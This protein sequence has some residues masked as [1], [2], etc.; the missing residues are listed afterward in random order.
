PLKSK[1]DVFGSDFFTIFPEHN[2]LYNDD[3]GTL[4]SLEEFF[5]T[6]VQEVLLRE[7]ST[8]GVKCAMR[9][10]R[11]FHFRVQIYP[12][13]DSTTRMPFFPDTGKPRTARRGR[14]NPHGSASVVTPLTKHL[15]SQTTKRQAT[16][17]LPSSTPTCKITEA[18]VESSK[19]DSENDFTVAVSAKACHLKAEEKQSRTSVCQKPSPAAVTRKFAEKITGGLH[20]DS[21][22][23]A[24][25]KQRTEDAGRSSRSLPSSTR[26]ANVSQDATQPK[27]AGS[28]SASLQSPSSESEFSVGALIDSLSMDNDNVVSQTPRLSD[29]LQK[30]CCY[31]SGTKKTRTSEIGTMTDVFFGEAS[32]SQAS[33]TTAVR[34]IALLNGRAEGDA[35]MTFFDLF[36]VNSLNNDLE[37]MRSGGRALSSF[38]RVTIEFLDSDPEAAD[39]FE[40]ALGSLP[41]LRARTA[42]VESARLAVAENNCVEIGRGIVLFVSFL[43][44][45]TKDD[46]LRTA[47]SV[48]NVKLC[49]S[50]EGAL[51]SV[52]ELPG[53]VLVVPQAC[54][55]GKRKG[56]RVQY[57]GL[58][59]KDTGQEFYRIFVEQCQILMSERQWCGGKRIT[60]ARSGT[61]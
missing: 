11:H 42:T 58:V 32:A 9:A 40:P 5:L 37:C 36:R 50:G 34:L 3:A 29:S 31:C 22:T 18:N 55:A 4:E 61:Y 23:R 45:A 19:N 51:V 39:P 35:H 53:D 28:S 6:S 17:S 16:K 30:S 38:A 14:E 59:S 41:L 49:D 47:K 13:L 52:L 43:E 44:N 48:L 7:D 21:S 12:G 1:D 33:Q 2:P 25:G 54:L 56:K 10:H 46:V 57:H 27:E 20:K 60:T 15:P 26:L 8:G 24:T